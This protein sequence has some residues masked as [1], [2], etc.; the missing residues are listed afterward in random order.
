MTMFS[1]AKAKMQ[2]SLQASCADQ[3]ARSKRRASVSKKY[4]RRPIPGAL[5]AR[6]PAVV[7]QGL[8]TAL[9]SG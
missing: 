6:A 7:Q 2:S 3:R 9:R 4:A 1:A 8:I 5:Q